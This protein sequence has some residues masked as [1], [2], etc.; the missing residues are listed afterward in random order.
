MTP[1][2]RH[3]CPPEMRFILRMYAFFLLL[4]ASQRIWLL[5]ESPPSARV[6]SAVL[7]KAFA[8]GMRF[9]L[10]VGSYLLAPVFLLLLLSRRRCCGRLAG[11]LL[12]AVVLVSFADMEYF[13]RTGAR[14]APELFRSPGGEAGAFA[15]VLA[16]PSPSHLAGMALF[17]AVGWGAVRRGLRPLPDA[18]PLPHVRESLLRT[19]GITVALALMVLASR[20]GIGHAPLRWR[21]AAF[22]GY[23][24]ADQLARNGVFALGRGG[25]ERLF[26]P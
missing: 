17:L 15:A 6:P 10:A 5:A 4:F 23:P 12:P 19:M 21:D 3:L 1:S 20:G 7:F 14:F 25:W 11:L 16:H 9:D 24:L 13:R 18:D 8:V 2:L 26:S 22:S